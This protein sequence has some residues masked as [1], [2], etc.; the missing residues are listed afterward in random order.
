MVGNAAMGAAG[1]YST[2]AI[3]AAVPAAAYSYGDSIGGATVI[4]TVIAIIVVGVVIAAHYNGAAVEIGLA[5]SPTAAIVAAARITAIT[6]ASIAAACVTATGATAASETAA[7]AGVRMTAASTTVLGR[8]R[9][10]K[11][12]DQANQTK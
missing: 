2:S 11:A 7:A 5:P 4:G 12:D 10:G 9:A 3:V 1:P 6:A 8:G